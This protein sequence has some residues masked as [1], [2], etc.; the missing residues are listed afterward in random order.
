MPEDLS[1]VDRSVSLDDQLFQECKAFHGSSDRLPF[2]TQGSGW[3]AAPIYS[4]WDAWDTA[5]DRQYSGAGTINRIDYAAKIGDLSRSSLVVA[6][7]RFLGNVLPEARLE[8]KESTGEKGESKVIPEHPLTKLW[9]RPNDFYSGSTLKK[10][11]AFSWILSGNAYILKFFN[12]TKTKPL[13]LWYEPHWT[14]RPVW[15]VDG[16]E[17]ISNYEV[18]RNG[19]WTPVPV[20][21]VIHLRDGI[22]PYNQ[23]LGF[24]GIES[25]LRELYADMEAANYYGSLMGG[26]AIPPFMV[27]IDAG[28]TM[29]Q[30][31]VTEFANELIRKT[32]GSRRGEPI[33]A[34]GAKA[35]KLGFNPRELDLRES[36]YMAEDRFCAVMGIPAVVMELGSGLVHCLPAETR[37]ST[38]NRGPV[39]INEVTTDDT[40]WA[41]TRDGLQPRRVLWSGQTGIGQQVYRIKTRNRTVSAT[42]NHPFPVSRR[43]KVPAPRTGNRNSPEWRYWIEWTCLKDLRVGDRIV[44]PTTLP[45]LNGKEAPDGT[46]VSAHLMQ[47]LGAFVG[48]GSYSND[49]CGAIDISIPLSD[50][51]AQEYRT[52]SLGLFTRRANSKQ[53]NLK[54]GRTL[55]LAAELQSAPVSIIEKVNS[56]SFT[57]KHTYNWLQDLGLKRGARNKRIPSWVFGLT[58][59]LR[60]A[61]LRGL[62]DTDGSVSSRGHAVWRMASEELVKDMWHL[63]LGL[64]M[65]VSNIYYV[66]QPASCLPHKGHQEFYDSWQFTIMSCE[67]VRRIGSKDP[68]YVS[69]LEN[70]QEKKRTPARNGYTGNKILPLDCAF[71]GIQSIEPAGIEDVYDLTIEDTHNFL[72]DGVIVSNSIYNNVKQAM[73]RAY[74]SYVIPMLNHFEEELQVQLLE[75]FEGDNHRRYLRHDLSKVYALQESENEKASRLGALLSAGGI[76]RQELRSGMGYGPSLPGDE[77]VDKVFYISGSVSVVKPGEDPAAKAAEMETEAA[78]PAAKIAAKNPPLALAPKPGEPKKKPLAIVKALAETAGSPT[79]GL[80]EDDFEEKD[81]TDAIHWLKQKLHFKKTALLMEA[82]P[83]SPNG[84]NIER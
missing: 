2:P 76:T 52:L 46:P 30:E 11:I 24:S 56:F 45:N 77:E 78:E 1:P 29:K 62:L 80:G 53:Q 25:V 74:R 67:D 68:Q 6:A 79:E 69:Y 4:S 34:K 61:F 81:F 58:E 14:M 20:E 63:A 19:V 43:E 32:T 13:E 9:E 50:R 75:D 66:K 21:N 36:R 10:G 27:S 49:R 47:W 48:D 40:V 71:V 28:V 33:V 7:I 39:P 54:S 8:V 65:S 5:L 22:H 15:P 70:A 26:S 16:S 84:D 64:G 41:C 82:E 60:L 59:E 42:A 37:I 12:N 57:S 83:I 3:G 73:E 55:A 44:E 17:Y 18:N 72:A 38:A 23:R 31:Q 51:V 35:Y